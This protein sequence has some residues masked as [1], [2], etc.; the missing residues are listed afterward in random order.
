VSDVEADLEAG[1]PAAIEELQAFCRIPS[2]ST[3]P[4]YREGI[5]AAAAWLEE[6]LARAGFDHV[7]TA[8]LRFPVPR[9]TF[10]TSRPSSA[11]V[12]EFHDL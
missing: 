5:A 6:R 3:D 8:S 4:A 7:E 2:V 12:R 9:E 1:A 10:M 11:T